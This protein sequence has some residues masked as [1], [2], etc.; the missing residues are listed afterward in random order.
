MTIAT[1]LSGLIGAV[2]FTGSLVA[3]LQAGRE[4]ARA[5][6]SASRA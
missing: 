3:F 1:G 5:A 2:T 6:A 4:D